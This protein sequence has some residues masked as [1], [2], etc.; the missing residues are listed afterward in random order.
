MEMD[1]INSQIFNQVQSKVSPSHQAAVQPFTDLIQ[2]GL[3]P[4]QDIPG[5]YAIFT[6]G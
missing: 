3:N 1:V 6:K 2:E 4:D 5:C